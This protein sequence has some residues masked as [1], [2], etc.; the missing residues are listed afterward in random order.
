MQGTGA[1]ER[2]EPVTSPANSTLE[3]STPLTFPNF[4]LFSLFMVD[5]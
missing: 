4:V 3:I 2:K 1:S 5:K